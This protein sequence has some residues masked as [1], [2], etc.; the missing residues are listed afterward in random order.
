MNRRLI[1]VVGPSGAGKDSV[2][3]WLREQTPESATV[4]WARRTIDRPSSAES[5]AENH[6]S[7]DTAAFE[8]LLAEGAF[9]MHWS[10]NSHRYG[11]RPSELIRL[12]DS[13]WC[14]MVN[15][16]RA[17]LPLAARDYPGLTVLLIT[18]SPA[19]LRE[20][21]LARGRESV[22]A[23]E[24]R[25]QRHVAL[26]IPSGCALVEIHNDRTLEQAGEQS[27]NKLKALGIWPASQ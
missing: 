6:E 22:S 1:Y 9:A 2:L 21:L 12:K 23:V 27:L 25:L 10:A 3:S 20:R 15:G 11:I 18:A 19:V 16:S 13:S 17:H 14:V 8:R 26:D 24:A 4:Q 7:V 5:G